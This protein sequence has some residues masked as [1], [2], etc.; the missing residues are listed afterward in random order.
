[1]ED[2]AASRGDKGKAG[3]SGKA[4]AAGVG[5]AAAAVAAGVAAAG[6]A[7][8]SSV[9]RDD[10][11]TGTNKDTVAEAGTPRMDVGAPLAATPA[12]AGT[13]PASSAEPRASKVDSAA[14]AP[15]SDKHLEDPRQRHG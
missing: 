14:P 4:V 8:R 10:I 1:M 6:A 9:E 5:A 7:K 3:V 2:A 13:L 15:G 11:N 12:D